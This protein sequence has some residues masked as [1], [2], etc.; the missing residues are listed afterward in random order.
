ME[1]L[2][3]GLLRGRGGRGELRINGEPGRRVS[4]AAVLM[5][6]QVLGP[7]LSDLVFGGPGVRRQWL[8]WGV[9]HVEHST[10]MIV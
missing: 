10:N 8:D 2:W 1:G 7:L 3:Q 5:P 4:Q 6:V 9:F